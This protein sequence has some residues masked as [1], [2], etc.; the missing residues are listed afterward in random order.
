VH[1]NCST[2]EA[3]ILGTDVTY[4]IG[5][6]GRH[7][8]GNS[9]AVLTTAVLV[10]ADLALAALALAELKPSP[11]AALPSRSSFRADRR[12][13]STRATMP[14]RLPSVPR[15]PLLG[16]A[17]IGPQGRRI[18]VLGDMLELGPKGRAWHRGLLASVL[19]MRSILCSVVAR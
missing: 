10:G 4:K 9:L 12:S 7:L 2:V 6:P 13:S 3:Q 16:Q 5:A 19:A 18:A 15:W 14:I 11:V 8:V 1:S 17:R